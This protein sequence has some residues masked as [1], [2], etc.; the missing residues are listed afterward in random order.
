MARL[1]QLQTST[2][3]FIQGLTAQLQQAGFASSFR[4]G[5]L[6]VLVA[7]GPESSARLEG[8]VVSATAEAAEADSSRSQLYIIVGC[9][10]GG[11]LVLVVLFIALWFC[12]TS[13]K[14]GKRVAPAEPTTKETVSV[15][16]GGYRLKRSLTQVTAEETTPTRPE[17]PG[18]LSRLFAPREHGSKSPSTASRGGGSGGGLAVGATVQLFGLA[19]APHYNGLVGHVVAGPNEHGRYS[20]ELAVNDDGAMREGQTKAFKAENLRL[21]GSVEEANPVVVAA[22]SG[23]A[24]RSSEVGSYRNARR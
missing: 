19:A 8:A 9:V 16:D 18:L 17:K 20:V 14:H 23:P 22:T 21:L 15:S 5:A 11:F 6:A 3:T 1:Q 10:V 24:G 4:A 12:L 7:D 13:N 2:Y